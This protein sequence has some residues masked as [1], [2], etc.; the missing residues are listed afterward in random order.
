MVHRSLDWALDPGIVP[1]RSVDTEVTHAV[2]QLFA[3]MMTVMTMV[4]VMT[5]QDHHRAMNDRGAMVMG[6]DQEKTIH[7]FH[8]YD[9]GGA[10]DIAVKEASD[11]KNLDAIRAHLPHIAA[12]FAAGNFGAPMLIHDSA[13]VPGT[14]I[15][16]ERK[17]KVRYTYVQTPMGGRVDITTA[18]PAALAALHDF[19][20]YQ[21]VE[22]RT[23]DPVNVTARP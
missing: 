3:T 6:F 16:K 15:L 2:A 5:G 22:H 8:L 18:D 1:T 10:I 9:D 14:D 11:T 4:A 12:M 23:N 7:H 13:A 19:L 21:I 20:R 17:D